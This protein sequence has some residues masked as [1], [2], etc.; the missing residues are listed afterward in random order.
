MNSMDEYLSSITVCDRNEV[1]IFI[2]YFKMVECITCMSPH[3][4]MSWD[5][6]H[7]LLFET[8]MPQICLHASYT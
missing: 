7:G 4:P 6:T 2:S 3:G 5:M 1:G 8:Y